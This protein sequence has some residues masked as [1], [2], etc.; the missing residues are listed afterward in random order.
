MSSLLQASPVW[1]GGYGG[2]AV[3]VGFGPA[4]DDPHATVVEPE[5]GHVQWDQNSAAH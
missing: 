1:D 3:V 4:D 5:V 2:A